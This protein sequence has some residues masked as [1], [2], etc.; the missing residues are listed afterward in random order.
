M[1]G[2]DISEIVDTLDKN[3]SAEFF[4]RE[5]VA[6]N[7]ACIRFRN[8][9]LRSYTQ[10]DES[11]ELKRLQRLTR[12]AERERDRLERALDAEKRERTRAENRLDTALRDVERLGEELER[13][14]QADGISKTQEIIQSLRFEKEELEE[15]LSRREETKLKLNDELQR[16]RQRERLE[17][18]DQNGLDSL[19]GD[20]T[21]NP[22][23]LSLVG[24]GL[25]IMR[26]P[27]RKF[28]I[29]K[30]VREYKD[31]GRVWTE[32][33]RLSV[34][35]ERPTSLQ[36]ALDFGNFKHV[37]SSHPKCFGENAYR[38]S[39]KLGRIQTNR[40][41]TIHPNFEENAATQR[42]EALLTDI[43]DVLRMI[44]SSEEAQRVEELKR[45]L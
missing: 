32:L 37:V 30:L 9:Q 13:A 39:D 26:D 6:V 33:D 17:R 4:D 34:D 3:A 45:A 16:F 35:T 14:S 31:P 38:L 41:R 28:I 27:V 43:S 29:D 12:K 22:G 11:T 25:N 44:G 18:N 40:N 20:P 10:V 36:S 42:S 7:I 19:I 15:K 2:T 23:Q 5:F 21:S 24:H 8:E 1:P